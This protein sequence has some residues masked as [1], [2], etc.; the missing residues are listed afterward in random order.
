MIKLGRNGIAFKLRRIMMLTSGF[1]LL[2]ASM[3]YISQEYLSYR[4]AL[5]Q[6]IQVLAQV[7]TTNSTAAM[8]FD[9]PSTASKLLKSLHVEE[10]ITSAVLLKT[11]GSFFADFY[12][13]ESF[14]TKM[15]RSATFI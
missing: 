15:K 12:T 7:I 9:D 2:L 14:K 4:E 1:A 10:T 13:D 5:L 11:D 8:T 3:V 6:R